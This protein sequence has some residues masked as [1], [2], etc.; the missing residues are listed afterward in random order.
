MYIDFI[1]S[2]LSNNPH[3]TAVIWNHHLISSQSLLNKI[4]ETK[5]FLANHN[6]GRGSIVGLKGDFSPNAIAI[7][8]AL[9]EGGCIITPF[10]ISENSQSLAE[11]AVIAKIEFLIEVTREDKINLV[12]TFSPSSHTLFSIIRELDHPGLILFSSGTSGS[13]KAAVHNFVP[14]LDK[15]KTSRKS[16]VTINFLL[17]DHWGGLNTLFSVLS[18]NGTIVCVDKRTPEEICQLIEKYSATLL[19]TTPTFLNM[20]FLSNLIEKYDLSS[21]KLI[22][23][24][25]EPMPVPTLRKLTKKFAD[26]DIQQTYGLIEVGVLSA[27]SLNRDSLWVKIGG[28]GYETR[29]VDGLLEIKTPS[30]ILGYMNAESPITDDGWFRTGDAV[31]VNGEFFKI[32]GRKSELINVGGEK[33]FP[34]E[35]ED[36]I[37]SIDN[38]SDAIVY[39]EKNTIIGNIICVKVSLENPEDPHLF[40]QRLKAYCHNRLEKFKVPV[41]VTFMDGSEYGARYKKKRV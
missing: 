15:F 27:K 21:L 5:K 20:L 31:E 18:S 1:K 13:P 38:V 36:V 24:G 16:Y 39:A 32:L 37:L 7:L 23:Y 34:S 22:T 17:F 4:E 12:E 2:S 35:V 40:T 3:H 14:L 26:V 29:V 41:K 8:C 33:V 25:A 11:K 9:I 30:M 10:S 19:P 6:I 28:K